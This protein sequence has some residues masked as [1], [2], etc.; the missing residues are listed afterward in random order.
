M[1]PYPCSTQFKPPN[2]QLKFVL[3]PRGSQEETIAE[4]RDWDLWGPLLLCMLLSVVLSFRAPDGHGSAIFALVFVV[5]WVGSAAVTLNAQ[6]LGGKISFFQSV[7]VLGYCIFP[8]VL[9][10]L[11]SLLWGNALFRLL[12]VIASFA[13]S[14]RAS[15]LFI[16]QLVEPERRALAAYPALLFYVCISWMVFM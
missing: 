3:K 2:R 9:A 4:L 1:I 11:L 15:V 12:V 14:T 16:S 7:C 6:L 10:A 13:W 8:L 5:V